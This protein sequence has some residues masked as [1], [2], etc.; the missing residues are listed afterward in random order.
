MIDRDKDCLEK[1]EF[2]KI[3]EVDK[4][5]VERV[6][7]WHP[8]IQVREV[9]GLLHRYSIEGSYSQSVPKLIKPGAGRCRRL[10]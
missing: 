1:A 6:V 9:G 3:G 2:S 10:A 7:G 8:C 4:S 5:K